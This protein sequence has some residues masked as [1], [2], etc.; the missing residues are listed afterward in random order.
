MG[1][2]Y[3]SWRTS[4]TRHRYILGLHSL[5]WPVIGAL[6]GCPLPV[7]YKAGYLI[8]EPAAKEAEPEY[9]RQ[10][11][12]GNQAGKARFVQPVV[13]ADDLDVQH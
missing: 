1:R 4:F 9:D 10:V 12:Y 13:I 7:S 11:D 5:F 3:G 8:P 2:H 6:I